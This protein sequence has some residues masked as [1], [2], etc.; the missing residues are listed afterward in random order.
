MLNKIGY[1]KEI[2]FNEL[3]EHLCACDDLYE[4]YYA[5]KT[6]ES[7]YRAGESDDC[8]LAIYDET[9]EWKRGSGNS[10]SQWVCKFGDFSE[11]ANHPIPS[12]TKQE[13]VPK[14]YRSWLTKKF[15]AV[16]SAMKHYAELGGRLE[17]V[18]ETGRFYVIQYA[19]RR[20]L[21]VPKEFTEIEK[22]KDYDDLTVADIHLMLSGGNPN[23]DASMGLSVVEGE[24]VLGLPTSA[25]MSEV[26]SKHEMLAEQLRLK[27]AEAKEK[28]ELAKKEMERQ[29]AELREK[30]ELELA[31]MKE[32]VDKM[33]DSIFVL[34][35]NIFALRSLFGETFTLTQL[36]KGKTSNNPL[37]LYQKF[38]F[39]DEEFALLAV[40]EFGAFDGQH[41]TTTEIFKKPNVQAVFLPSE[42]CITFFRTSKDKKYYAY[43]AEMDGLKALEYYHE[44]QIGML[45]RNG[46]NVWLSFIDEEIFVE[47]NLFESAA[48]WAEAERK[49]KPGYDGEYDYKNDIIVEGKTKLRDPV[50]K[51]GLDKMMLFYVLEGLVNSTN[52]FTE[53]K[54][55]NIRVPSDKVIFSA[56]DA[57]LMSHK[58]PDFKTYFTSWRELNKEKDVRIGDT[59][60]I[61][62]K[63]AASHMDYSWD[64]HGVEE[65]RS[66]G[67]ENRARDAEDILPGLN[68]ISFIEK[69]DK[70]YELDMEGKPYKTAEETGGEPI[71]YRKQL[72][73]KVNTD[74][75]NVV[76]EPEYRFFV[77]AKRHVDDYYRRDAYGRLPSRVNNVNLRVYNDE[78]CP[79][80]FINSNYVLSW[81]EQKNIGDWYHGNYVYLVEN[82]FHALLKMLRGREER[83]NTMIRVHIPTFSGTPDELDAVTEWKKTHVVR[84]FT[85]WQAKRFATWY[86][87]NGG[88]K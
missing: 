49:I 24:G 41:G 45:I 51:K 55:V 86:N 52:I 47:D 12:W 3:L 85:E 59:I 20:Y 83:E 28:M 57:Q 26:K 88:R 71:Y 36:N 43:D 53:L 50:V 8:L 15:K 18:Y 11:W 73:G 67:Y 33:K 75:P 5:P 10:S 58:Y 72:Y 63:A 42:K 46:E 69:E 44:D 40:K 76:C 2:K 38:R 13:D 29:L 17:I 4:K 22:A 34:E 62:E 70:W 31:R 87:E 65:H 23:E 81:M 39:L 82:I 21:A 25:K 66:R 84:N 64:R 77:S 74:L 37:V 32:V 56:A 68:T 60:L 7:G 79:V 48:T 30:Q 14:E 78:F 19:A 9:K 80:D 27:E 61:I 54:G 16:Q 6:V 1:V 35:L